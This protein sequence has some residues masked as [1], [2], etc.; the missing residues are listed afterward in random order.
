MR[1][2][3]RFA[4]AAAATLATTA[5]AVT[6]LIGLAPSAGAATQTCAYRPSQMPVPSGA[7]AGAVTAT[8]GTDLFAGEIEY[9]V[10]GRTT[11]KHA[12][13]WSDGKVTDLG[14]V[15]DAD[16][17]LGVNDMNASGTVVG[18][19]WKLTGSSEG[20]PMGNNFPFRSSNGKLERLP[21]PEGAHDVVAR[22]IT[23][24]GDIYGDDPNHRT[25]YFWPADKPGTV[26]QPAGFPVG[27]RVEGVD[28]DGTVAVTAV[29]DVEGTTRAYLW[30]G[31]VA[32]ALAMPAGATNSTISSIS[33]GTVVGDGQ[34][35]D[36]GRFAVA[37][38]KDGRPS[39][40]PDGYGTSDVNSTGLILGSSAKSHSA[41]LWQ[42]ASTLTTVKGDGQFYTLGDDG[43][44]GGANAP[45]GTTYPR[46]PAVWRCS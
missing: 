3:R 24:N 14:T 31:G 17:I 21:V 18:Y 33:G 8:A 41:K 6:G 15:P 12:A 29:S 30:K 43:T 23:A 20:W 9:P 45:V 26:T 25:A 36:F 35:A 38:G 27:S 22:A 37:W 44:L 46:F 28:T 39:R 5:L 4:R 7:T 10:S 11:K 1:Y 34:T 32:K 16:Y 19:G 13:L 40:L 42:G 2:K